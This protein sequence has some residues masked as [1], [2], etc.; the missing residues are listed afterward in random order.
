MLNADDPLVYA[1]RE[2]TGGGHRALL[3]ARRTAR[4]SSSS[5]HVARGGIA[6]RDRG[7][8][9]RHPARPAAHPDRHR[10]RGAAH[11]RRRG[12][13]PAAERA[14]RDRRGVRAGHA[15]RRH[16]RRAA[17]VLPVAVDHAGPHERDPRAQRRT[18]ARRL[19]AQRG[20]DRGA[21]G[22]RAARTPAA[23]RYRRAHRA[24]RPARRR[25]SP[26]GP[27]VRAASIS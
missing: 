7:G 1:M 17:L 25:H 4:T 26:G 2:Q 11:A 24:R 3:D 9:L 12:A 21:G 20:R 23:K 14:R 10:A 27:A 6:A 5:D 16:P 19:R 18:R 22:V 13:V 8:H 15:L